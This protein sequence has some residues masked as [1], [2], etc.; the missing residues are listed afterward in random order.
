MPEGAEMAK[1]LQQTFAHRKALMFKASTCVAKV[2][3]YA[4][5]PFRAVD[6]R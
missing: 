3:I 1:L 5:A 2:V 6:R 4:P